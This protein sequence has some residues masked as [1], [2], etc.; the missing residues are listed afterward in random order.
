[1]CEHLVSTTSKGFPYS[2]KVSHRRLTVVLTIGAFGIGDSDLEFATSSA[3]T[4]DNCPSSYIGLPIPELSSD[5]PLTAKMTLEDW[6]QA[7]E[8][9]LIKH[10]MKSDAIEISLQAILD[11]LNILPRK[12]DVIQSELDFGKL[13]SEDGLGD[14]RRKV[15]EGMAS[16]LAEVKPAMLADFDGDRE[17]GRAFF[18][19]CCIYFMVVRDLFL[20]NQSQ[21]HWVLSFFKSDQAARFANKVLQSKSKGKGHYRNWE[22]FEKTFLDQF[23]P[24]NEQLTALTKLEGTSWYQG[25][26]PV[27]DYID[28]F[29]ELI[30]LVEYDEDKT[31]VIKF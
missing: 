29:Q 7:M 23:C 16:M 2:R 28:R 5:T 1:M 12:E 14:S 11:K 25:K 27:D 19:T 18:N 20:N 10:R 6:L 30:D 9:E 3:H 24:K 17:K 26:D 22:A 13:E 8:E 31:I 4:A 15:D 21:I